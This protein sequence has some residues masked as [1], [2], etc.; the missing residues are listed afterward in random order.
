MNLWERGICSRVKE[1]REAIRWQQPDFAAQIGITFDQLASIEYG[2]TPL[3]YEIA[4]MIAA[5][6]G[7]SLEWLAEGRVSPDEHITDNFPTPNAT[8]L[9]ETALLSEVSER[10]NT[11][12]EP[13]K[14]DG[15]DKTRHKIKLDQEDL[16]QRAYIALMIRSEVAGW[17]G[18]ANDP[19]A[20]YSSLTDFALRY[21]GSKPEEPIDLINARIAALALEKIRLETAMRLA[22][23][24]GGPKKPLTDVSYCA[25]TISVKP[26]MPGFLE[27]LNKATSQ[28]GAKTA[29]AKY[30]GLPLV[31]VSQWLSGDREPGGEN[32]LRLLKW[33]EQQE[34]QK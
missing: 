19:G 24:S 23:T 16:K 26:Q 7:V 31:S 8:G 25:N 22:L 9:A 15:P 18:S 21:I 6:F 3:R 13:S 27:R 11:K 33:V 14:F 20:F 30:L 34:R 29:L 28:R 4:W 17:V 5:T 32:T 12:H 10:F 2:R 1:L